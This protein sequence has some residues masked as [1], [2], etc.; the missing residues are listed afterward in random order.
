[1]VRQAHQPQ[2]QQPSRANKYTFVWKKSV[3]KNR[4]KLEAKIRCILQEIE[5]GIFYDNHSDDDPPAPIN[6]EELRHRIAQINRANK[7]K[8]AQ[9]QIA[10]VESKLIPKLEEYHQKVAICG[11]RN[12]YSKTDGW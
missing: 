9:K 10:E 11:A 8:K 1:M 7:S 5:A 6:P 12:S 3:E 4:E 2:A